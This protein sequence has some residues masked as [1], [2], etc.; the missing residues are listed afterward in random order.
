MLIGRGHQPKGV[1]LQLP[2]R[3]RAALDVG[4]ANDVL[5]EF[6]RDQKTITPNRGRL[7]VGA[8]RTCERGKIESSSSNNTVTPL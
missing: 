4:V 6:Y 8:G 1:V 2:F 3:L 7:G 5:V